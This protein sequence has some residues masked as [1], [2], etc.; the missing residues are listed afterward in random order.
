MTTAMLLSLLAALPAQKGE[1]PE[2]AQPKGLV[3]K[4]V[5]KKT[6]YKLDFGGKKKADFV[7][8][9][10]AGT[11]EAPKVELEL[12]IINNT[13]ETLRIRK[14]GSTTRLTLTLKGEG[15]IEAN[16]GL[17]GVRPKIEYV[18]LEP[19]GKL[20]IPIDRLVNVGRPLKKDNA[21]E[22]RFYWTEPGDYKV[23][24]SLYALVTPQGGGKGMQRYETFTSKPITLKVEK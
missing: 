19:K 14:S 6:T 11:A 10:K 2:P 24:A 18:V 9:A 16:A 3:T 8:D 23:T 1:D 7:S 5:A 12:V 22:M 13:K 15:A 21:P 20:V 17:S 4:L